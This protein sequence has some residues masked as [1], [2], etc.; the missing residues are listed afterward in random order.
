[1]SVPKLR[2][3]CRAPKAERRGTAIIN[4]Y[5]SWHYVEVTH[6]DESGRETRLN[7]VQSVQFVAHAGAET[8]HAVVTF[9]NIDLDA[10]IVIDTRA[11][12]ALKEAETG[13][14]C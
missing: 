14:T 2:I 1:V 4:V 11:A 8:P 10:E 6:I 7:N 5:P 13:A 3:S 12:E 9:I